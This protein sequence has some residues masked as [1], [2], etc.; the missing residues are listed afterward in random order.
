[1]KHFTAILVALLMQNAQAAPSTITFGRSANVVSGTP[2]HRNFR[3]DMEAIAKS[4]DSWKKAHLNETLYACQRNPE[5]V[6]T[7]ARK[8]S[9]RLDASKKETLKSAKA[10]EKAVDD[11]VGADAT[12]IPDTLTAEQT[13]TLRAKVKQLTTA[14]KQAQVLERL[15]AQVAH[16]Y[17]SDAPQESAVDGNCV[18]EYRQAVQKAAV[19]SETYHGDAQA[20]SQKLDKLTQQAQVALRHALAT[21]LVASGR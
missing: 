16:Y 17:R 15:S 9:D 21:T 2:K 10:A 20:L 19:A 7:L 6:A 13:D 11:S 4:H 1:M 18:A 5:R 14:Q 8:V 3:Q 12:E